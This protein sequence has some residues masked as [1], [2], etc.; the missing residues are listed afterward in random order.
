[1]D[2]D[3][4]NLADTEGGT[5]SYPSSFRS[6]SEIASDTSPREKG[7]GRY[8]EIESEKANVEEVKTWDPRQM[9][10]VDNSKAKTKDE[11]EKEEKHKKVVFEELLD[12]VPETPKE[13]PKRERRG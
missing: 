13:A 12:E 10:I 8:E 7:K 4:G 2:I 9:E 5:D 1:M 3:E 6:L 11:E